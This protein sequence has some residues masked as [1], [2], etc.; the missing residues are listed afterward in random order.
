MHPSFQ[1]LFVTPAEK[2]ALHYIG[3]MK[4]GR[5]TSG[6]L[7]DEDDIRYADV[8]EGIPSFVRP[9]DDGWGTDAQV[10]SLLTKHGVRRET[11]I[12]QN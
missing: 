9:E 12:S 5:W 1:N 6:R 11:L 7:V 4:G 10:E 8:K 3:E 2:K